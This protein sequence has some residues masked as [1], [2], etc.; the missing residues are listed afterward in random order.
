LEELLNGDAMASDQDEAF[1]AAGNREGWLLFYGFSSAT[2]FAP[3]AAPKKETL[4]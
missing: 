4:E 1:M 3:P 2:F